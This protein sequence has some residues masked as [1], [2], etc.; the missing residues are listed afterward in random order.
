MT[1][2]YLNSKKKKEYWKYHFLGLCFFLILAIYTFTRYIP[3]NKDKN[4]CL[5]FFILSLIIS[6]FILFNLFSIKNYSVTKNKL[7]QSSFL[8]KEKKVYLLDNI[9]NWTEKQ[10][11]SRSEEWE[12]IILYFKNGETTKISSEYFEN[13]LEIKNEVT[14]DKK[15]NTELEELIEKR[16][17]KKIAIICLIISSLFFYGAYNAL[18]I[19]N[20]KNRDIIVFG[21]KTSEEIKFI[22][23]KYS[24]IEI[25]LETY[26]GLIFKIQGDALKATNYK[27][28]IKDIKTGDSIFIGIYKT[29]YRTKLIKVDSLS[30]T[31]KYFP[32]EYVN[33]ESIKT[34]KNNYLKLTDNN[35]SKSETKS[36][37]CFVSTICGLF[38]ALCS[39]H[40]LT[41]K[42]E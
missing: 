16:T 37:L 13:Y 34:L 41:T 17:G 24:S 39:K 2:I 40:S 18:Q 32:N 42:S 31:D 7:I 26:P 20:I 33:V 11:K 38:F 3:E 30:F 5:V 23:G 19:E 22:S 6:G 28:L 1:E 36:W 15:R 21:D 4:F 10:K 14:K 27:N 8:K 29:K 9:E 25:K 12:E 35:L